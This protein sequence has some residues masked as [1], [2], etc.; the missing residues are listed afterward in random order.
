MDMHLRNKAVLLSGGSRG[1][2]RCILEKL[3]SDGAMVTFCG[4]NSHS[5]EQTL[6]ELGGSVSAQGV[7]GDVLESGFE[8]EMIARSIEKFGRIDGVVANVGSGRGSD[9]PNRFAWSDWQYNIDI[10]V[11]HPLELAMAAVP[12]LE[13]SGGGSI[14]FISSISGRL[15]GP[16]IQYGAT[17]AMMIYVAQALGRTLASRGIRVNSVSPGSI[18]TE[19]GHWDVMLKENP[20]EYAWFLKD[21]FPGGRLGKP[22]EVA[23][24]VSF[25]LSENSS[26]VNG[27]DIAADG[28]QLKPTN[29]KY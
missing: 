14:V 16:G 17:K 21:G 22:E 13:K 6:R 12:H 4:R 24:I 8:R 1:I 11:K 25:L 3:T 9:D 10:N 27:A 2:G 20:E 7:V 26:L 23:N 19:N 5:I 29:R 18:Q 15:F 28:G